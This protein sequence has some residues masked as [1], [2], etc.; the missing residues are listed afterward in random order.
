MAQNETPPPE[1]AKPAAKVKKPKRELKDPFARTALTLVGTGTGAEAYWLA[2]INNKD[3]PAEERSDLIEDLNEEGFSDADHPGPEDLPLI[4]SRI[5][6]IIT[7][8]PSSMDK[9]NADAFAEAL[10][11]LTNMYVQLTQ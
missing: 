6:M 7:L 8:A 4:A 3:L 10:K 5:R 9:V 1:P 2:A 11:D